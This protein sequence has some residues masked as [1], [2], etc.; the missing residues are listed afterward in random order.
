MF[1]ENFTWFEGI[2]T[3]FSYGP[4]L[5]NRWARGG[6]SWKISYSAS[7]SRAIY[8][9][10]NS[11]TLINYTR[12]FLLLQHWEAT[13]L[14]Q[15]KELFCEIRAVSCQIRANAC[16]L[17]KSVEKRLKIKSAWLFIWSALHHIYTLRLVIFLFFK[18][19]RYNMNKWTALFKIAS[20]LF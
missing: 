14:G 2:C 18:R 10:S 19:I 8:I 4:V 1:I 3:I 15:S 13:E 20:F 7:L 6:G 5:T 17:Q 12:R 16:R 11:V 9:M